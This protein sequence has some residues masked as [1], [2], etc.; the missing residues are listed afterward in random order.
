VPVWNLRTADTV[1]GDLRVSE[2][3]GIRLS[4]DAELVK[5]AV[6]ETDYGSCSAGVQVLMRC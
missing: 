1:P 3:A 2:A 4:V 6:I 5:L